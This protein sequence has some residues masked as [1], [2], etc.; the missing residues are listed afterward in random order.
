M[1]TG[2]TTEALRTIFREMGRGERAGR[3]L[4]FTTEAQRHRG[5]FFTTEDTDL[6]EFFLD[7]KDTKGTKN[8]FP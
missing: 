8:D 7:H 6:R 4:D 3:P 2:W 1:T 5:F